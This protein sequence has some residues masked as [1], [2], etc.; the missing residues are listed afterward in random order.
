MPSMRCSTSVPD[1]PLHD[2]TRKDYV[3]QVAAQL[4]GLSWGEQ[5]AIRE[6]IDAHIEDHI[7]GLLELGYSEELAE[8]R[9]MLRMGDPQEVG[10]ELRAQYPVVWRIVSRL[11]ILMLLLMACFALFLAPEDEWSLLDGLGN[12]TTPRQ[13]IFHA[14]SPVYV[15]EDVDI[16]FTVG[17]D[18][19]RVLHLAI[20]EDSRLYTG[21]DG[22]SHW[23]NEPLVASVYADAHDRFPGGPV[24]RIELILENQRGE[25]GRDLLTRSRWW[26]DGGVKVPI[27]PEDTYVIL[28]CE[29]FGS[30]I[31][32]ELPLPRE[33]VP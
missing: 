2:M 27:Q 19:V 3:E 9:T 20:G 15:G 30:E 31:C 23:L 26:A 11:S 25:Q 16:T 7:C 17:D 8:E 24:G 13:H 28:R 18:T 32:Y 14:V 5:D 29:Q 21:E 22:M 33:E 6:E 4:S 12:R 10:R 1:T